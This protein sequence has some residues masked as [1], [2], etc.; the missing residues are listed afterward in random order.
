MWVVVKVW[1]SLLF[2]EGIGLIKQG[3]VLC[4]FLWFLFWGCLACVAYCVGVSYLVFDIPRN[5]KVGGEVA[6]CVGGLLRQFAIARVY[7]VFDIPRNDKVGVFCPFLL[8]LVV[9]DIFLWECLLLF[10]SDCVLIRDYL[11]EN[12][13][14]NAC[15]LSSFLCI[16]TRNVL[17]YL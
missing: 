11:T 8:F 16:L 2:G 3:V 5:D 4:F 9:F 10:W 1:D 14:K 13:H 12:S 15:S 6:Y 7:F 17:I